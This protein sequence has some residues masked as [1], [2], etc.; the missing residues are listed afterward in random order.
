MMDLGCWGHSVVL[1]GKW[2]LPPRVCNVKYFMSSI[3]NA[4]IRI[5]LIVMKKFL[6]R[7]SGGQSLNLILV[8]SFLV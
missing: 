6:E 5:R 3:Y 2:V 8:F 1:F 7:K 4:F